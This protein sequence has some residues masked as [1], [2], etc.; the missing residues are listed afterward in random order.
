MLSPLPALPGAA[1]LQEAAHAAARLDL[2][3][4]WV[5]YAAIAVFAAAYL[6]VMLEEKLHIR[7]SK[8]VMLAAGVLWALLG[9]AYVRA[10]DTSTAAAAL[11]EAIGEYGELFL[12]VL[13]AMTFVNTM[14]ERQVFDA[15]RAWMVRK[16]FSLRTVFWL[17][18]G[19]SFF[20]SSQL[21]NMTT[22]LVMGAV[23]ITAGRGY[24][25]F[26]ALACINV[27]VAANAGG[28]WSPFGDIT[29]LMVWQA[30]R[31]GFFDFY[32]L[33]V[34]AAVAW[35]VPAFFMAL[36]IPKARPRALDEHVQPRRG[37]FGVVGLFALT[38]VLAVSSFN[39][40]KL[41]PVLGMTTGLALL[42][43]YGYYLRRTQPTPA[44]ARAGV[45]AAAVAAPQRSAVP[46]MAG[47]RDLD[48]PLSG[49]EP[50]AAAPTGGTPAGA[51]G[52]TGSAGASA[53]FDIYD[54]LRRSEWDTLMFFYGIMLSVGALAQ[55]GHLANLSHL[56]YG[57][58]GATLANTGVGLISAVIDN[59]PVMYA[60]LNMEPAM[61][62]AQW[63]L[64]TLTAGIGG[65]IFSIGS[66]AGVALMGQA[67]GTYT[68]FRHLRWSWAIALGYFLAVWVHL[69]VNGG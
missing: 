57:G 36:T 67:R 69:L 8:P 39:L 28:A 27:V 46:A 41:P 52:H 17:T 25:K 9:L 56:M 50:P 49:F 38:I 59:I 4:H 35:F 48:E 16:G 10:G 62:L 53:G 5:G 45:T 33:F 51:A 63:L 58:L 12:F 29:T 11:R 6:M 34:P 66:A 13:V 3:R 32:R 21:D 19:M 55:I 20:L 14:E 47:G 37:A 18:G 60:V 44:L 40:L 65:S 7:K 2:T 22:A 15:L 31:G 68:F 64:V 54:I 42:K 23:V 26:V 61:P 43:F 24:P 1:I 30:G